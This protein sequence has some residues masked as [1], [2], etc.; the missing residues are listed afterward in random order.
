MQAQPKSQL[1][2]KLVAYEGKLT[3]WGQQ[4]TTV[5]IAIVIL[6]ILKF[7]SIAVSFLSQKELA[8]I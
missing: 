4:D 8:M 5:H 7:Y 2:L 1:S 3:I 6:K